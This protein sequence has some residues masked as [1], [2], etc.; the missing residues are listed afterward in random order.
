MIGVSMGIRK[1]SI[2]FIR[3][4][5]SSFF[6]PPSNKITHKEETEAINIATNAEEKDVVQRNEDKIIPTEQ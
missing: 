6:Q 4:K 3:K 1:I 5:S 2:L